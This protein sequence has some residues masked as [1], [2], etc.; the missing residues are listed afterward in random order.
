MFLK[1]LLTLLCVSLA[2]VSFSQ[3]IG[4]KEKGEIIASTKKLFAQHY[5]YKNQV[6]PTLDYVDQQWKNGKYDSFTS[7]DEFTRALAGDL[8]HFTHDK[9][10]NF[11]H[12]SAEVA[13]DH[14]EQPSIPWGLLNDNFLNNGMTALQ[15][16]PGDIG[17]MNIKAMGDFEQVA[18]A[19]FNFVS[20]TQA[21]IIDVRGN[22]GGMLTNLLISY[23]LP[24]E[25]IHLNTISW[26]DHV[27]SIF[28][29]R[30]LN[31]PRYLNKP[32][33]V[34]TDHVTFSSAEEFAYDLQ[35]MKRATIVGERTGGGANPGGTMPIY[36]FPDGSRLDLYISMA[37]VENPIS[38]T[39]WEGT[40]I[41][42]DVA[43]E[44][45]TALQK[46]HTLALEYLYKKETN[47]F[48]KEKYAGILIK[49][50]GQN[51]D[52]GRSK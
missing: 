4:Q 8:Q 13:N 43:T 33:F 23:L 7:V 18:P 46:A 50:K 47:A 9:H 51:D 52:K 21:L 29:I 35:N 45:T 3:Q 6:K 34:L 26:N 25:K 5:H 36:S 32:V 17:Y 48:I 44:P 10:L 2:S 27:D 28:N 24:D 20:N 30:Q 49:V 19:A 12:Q 37:K 38:K 1:K 14:A 39:N 16:L 41:K 31:G 22:G 11:F 15:I 42:P 40:G